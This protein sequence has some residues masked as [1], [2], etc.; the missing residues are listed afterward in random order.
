M[1]RVLPLVGLLAFVA[2]GDDGS[3]IS[4]DPKLSAPAR[5]DFGHVVVGAKATRSIVLR[6]AGAGPANV[7]VE[8]PA[9]FSAEE[10]ELR[11]P[12]QATRL[13][14]FSLV[15]DAPGRYEG[16]ATLDWHKGILEVQLVAE[17]VEP[18]LC[19]PS[20]DCRSFTFEPGRGCVETRVP[21]GTRCEAPCL[22]DAACSQGRCVGT[23]RDCSD[24]DPCTLDTCDPMLGCRNI[25]DPELVCE[26]DDPC[27]VAGCDPDGGCRFEPVADGTACGP[28]TCGVSMVCIGGKCTTRATPEGGKC[29]ASTPCQEQGRCV[30]GVCVQPPQE[31]LRLVW[32][33]GPPSGWR[34]HFDGVGGYFG[35][36]YWVECERNA[37]VLASAQPS[38]SGP[39]QRAP[40]FSGGSVAS[41]GRL[42]FS[43]GHI[44]SSYRRG[45]ITIHSGDDLL[46]VASIDLAEALPAEAWEWEAVEIA[47]HR[48]RG[49]ALVEARM[50]GEPVQGWA[51]AFTIPGGEIEWAVEMN[52]I[53]EGLVVDERGRLYFTWLH[54][55]S[56][57]SAALVSLSNAGSER[58]RHPVDFNA[59][60]AVASGRLL[61]GNAELRRIEDGA[62]VGSIPALVPLSSRSALLNLEEG[63]LFGYPIVQCGV[64]RLCP[65]WDPHL[66]GFDADGKITWLTRV[67]SGESWDRTEPLRTEGGSILFAQP[68]GPTAVRRYL[69]E[70]LRMHDGVAKVG[71]RCEFPGDD[72]AYVGPM[73]LHDGH[74]V[75][76][77]EASQQLEAY[78]LGDDWKLAERGWVTAYGGPDRSGRPR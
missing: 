44:V 54:R 26:T 10:T 49:F 68:A 41:R 74:L 18:Q 50:G 14:A 29:G 34:L 53:F 58:W 30:E 56:T 2:C 46:Q 28:A 57:D 32:S 16:R 45:R 37:C 5:L 38:T 22:V 61:D 21:D 63:M 6:N 17:A 8:V 64:D 24:G 59:P 1:K 19:P 20:D 67:V 36:I 4:A 72:R 76:A 71:F 33:D 75:V 12:G 40:L 78:L 27:L 35:R 65:D 47:A 39:T 60:L 13:L 23:P 70:E 69:L 48:D 73:S 31:P 15:A 7:V 11:V 9:P 51:I 3:T 52:G 25:A 42:L 55:D 62:P 77:D 66:L 43:E